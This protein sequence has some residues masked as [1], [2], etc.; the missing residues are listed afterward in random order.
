MKL[1]CLYPGYCIPNEIRCENCY[2]NERR[3]RPPDS[4]TH[5]LVHL[6]S[7]KGKA[8]RW[9]GYIDGKKVSDGKFKETNTKGRRKFRK[10]KR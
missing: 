10:P 2:K 3:T 7:D 1:A 8:I 5:E 4:R 9:E 6:T